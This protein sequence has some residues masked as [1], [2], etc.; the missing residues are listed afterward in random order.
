M[1]ARM[2]TEL[3]ELAPPGR[4]RRADP[5]LQEMFCGFRICLP[6]CEHATGCKTWTADQIGEAIEAARVA[7]DVALR[8]T[9][10][11]QAEAAGLRPAATEP[12]PLDFCDIP[13]D[14]V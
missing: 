12:A 6:R 1:T 2:T 14:P 11:K 7:Q 3:P 5:T 13:I 10:R 8:R 9:V 4:R